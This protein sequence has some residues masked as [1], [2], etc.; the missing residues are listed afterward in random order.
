[1]TV[2]R[3]RGVTCD[4]RDEP[5]VCFAMFDGVVWVAKWMKEERGAHDLSVL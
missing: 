1:M 2:N 5:L 3:R 4:H